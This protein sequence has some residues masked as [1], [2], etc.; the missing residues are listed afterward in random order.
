MGCPINKDQINQHF[1]F[2]EINVNEFT[3]STIEK[4]TYNNGHEELLFL[5]Y[6]ENSFGSFSLVCVCNVQ[7]EVRNYS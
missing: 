3:D 4:G 7:G 1:N 5:A 6:P 2:I